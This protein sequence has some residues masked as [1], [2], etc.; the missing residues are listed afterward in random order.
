[1]SNGRQ[2]PVVGTAVAGSAFAPCSSAPT[3]SAKTQ[4]VDTA[5][6]CA[7][8]PTWTTSHRRPKAAATCGKIYNPCATPATPPRPLFKVANGGNVTK[9]KQ[10]GQDHSRRN[11]YCSNECRVIA[12]NERRKAARR[13]AMPS[14]S[15]KC[16][17]CGAA[18]DS[19]SSARYKKYC[20]KQ[21]KWAAG[22]ARIKAGD[23]GNYKPVTS[24]LELICQT[25]GVRFVGEPTAK[26]CSNECR[27]CAART[28]KTCPVCNKEHDSPRSLYEYYCSEQ[29]QHARHHCLCAW[30]GKEY[31]RGKSYE[32]SGY[33]SRQCKLAN[34]RAR[35]RSR[36]VSAAQPTQCTCEVC[37]S[38]FMS[39]T[40][41]GSR[42]CTLRCEKKA[43]RRKYGGTHIQ[44]ARRY[45]V[46]YEYFDAYNILERDGWMC[47]LC[48]QPTPKELRGTIEWNAPELDHVV[49]LSKGGTHTKD[50]VRCACRKC[51]AN[52][53][54]KVEGPLP[55]NP[56]VISAP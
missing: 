3:Q 30:C 4:T 2:Q 14:L 41:T 13:E 39:K 34:G 10:C 54:N 38:Q 6:R 24:K 11:D 35:E 43:Y 46:R 25:C 16:E 8:P 12:R 50:N 26:Y 49:P 23:T 42:Y 55:P 7:P 5:G 9:C 45:R 20:S 31:R 47:Y 1:M 19:T 33:C 18:I 27:T 29:C 51:N 32:G 15:N 22:K 53:S 44:R 52:K 37:G 48:G 36:Y 17:W 40:I 56:L 28:I 21:C